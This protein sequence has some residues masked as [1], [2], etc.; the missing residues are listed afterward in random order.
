MIEVDSSLLE[1]M[2]VFESRWRFWH[3]DT[4][5]FKFTFSFI[6]SKLPV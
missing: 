3:I 2:K 6:S 4:I 1:D 5:F